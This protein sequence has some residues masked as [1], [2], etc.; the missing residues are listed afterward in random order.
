MIENDLRQEEKD[1]SS[2]NENNRSIAE[3]SIANSVF[4][5]LALSSSAADKFSSWALAGV[6]ATVALFLNNIETV[7]SALSG[8]GF[9]Y[10]IYCLA[11][12]MV[13][14]IFSKYQAVICQIFSNVFQSFEEEQNQ[15]FQEHEKHEKVIQ[16]GAKRLGLEMD[17]DIRM[18]EIL[19]KLTEMYPLSS[20]WFVKILANRTKNN[21]G[22]TMY[23]PA[24]TRFIRQMQ[25]VFFQILFVAFGVVLAGW[26]S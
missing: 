4:K 14:G 2:Y 16:Q 25:F 20:R 3:G 7:K 22:N 18:S 23:L 19:N 12:S 10:I 11:A 9:R 13:C 17:T 24:A 15:I 6:G 8:N 5:N 21:K 26:F 1:L